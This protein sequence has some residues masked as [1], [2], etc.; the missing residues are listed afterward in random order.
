VDKLLS[1]FPYRVECD[2]Q[3]TP[4]LLAKL[5]RANDNLTSMIIREN[6]ASIQQNSC[7]DCD[8]G[9]GCKQHPATNFS[10]IPPHLR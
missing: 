2:E 8:K 4:N 10:R 5:V 9:E 6:V 1:L 3:G 7:R